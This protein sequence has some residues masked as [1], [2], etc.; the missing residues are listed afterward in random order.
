M[1]GNNTAESL[2]AHGLAFLDWLRARGH[3]EDD[4]EILAGCADAFLKGGPLAWDSTPHL[5]RI[6][7]LVLDTQALDGS[8]SK[9]CSE[10]QSPDDLYSLYH[11]VWVCVDALRPLR[12]D[13]ANPRNR[14]LS[15]S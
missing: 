7:Q 5:G 3:Y 1:Y 13:M 10:E 12:N 15:L 11:P 9:D 14:R 8:W 2:S 6:L 4:P